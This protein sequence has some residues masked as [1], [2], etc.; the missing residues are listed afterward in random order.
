MNTRFLLMSAGVAL[1]VGCQTAPVRDEQS[2]YFAPPAGSTLTLNRTL[3]VAGG[4]TRIYFQGGKAGSGSGV[5]SFQGVDQY[6][7]NC[8]LQMRSKSSGLR[9]LEPVEFRIERV[10]RREEWVMSEPVRLAALRFLGGSGGNGDGG[11]SQIY[12]TVMYARRTDAGR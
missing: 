5:L 7:P 9:T 10:E 1:L 11:D 6:Y 4:S 8:Y 12:R 3:E 2:P